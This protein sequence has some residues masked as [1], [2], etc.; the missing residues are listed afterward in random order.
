MKKRSDARRIEHIYCMMSKRLER[1]ALL[2]IGLLLILVI[3]CQLLLLVPDLKKI[4]TTI[5]RL[6]GTPV[7]MQ[8]NS[9]DRNG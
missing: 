3:L 2:F 8:S 9:K 6:E 7:H 5:D 1:R 4:M